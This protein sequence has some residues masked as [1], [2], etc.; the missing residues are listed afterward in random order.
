ME[1]EGG[2]RHISEGEI[3]SLCHLNILAHASLSLMLTHANVPARCHLY[4][5]LNTVEGLN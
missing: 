4:A 2:G 5:V 1:R 3:T